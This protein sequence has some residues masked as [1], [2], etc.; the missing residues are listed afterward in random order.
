ME[1]TWDSRVDTLGN[2]GHDEEHSLSHLPGGVALPQ[3]GVKLKRERER[4]R[5]TDVT[6]ALP[7]SLQVSWV[8]TSTPAPHDAM[9]DKYS[10]DIIRKL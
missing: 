4:E 6:P 7:S 1:L 10:I 8:S 5:G 9:S 3:S 2:G